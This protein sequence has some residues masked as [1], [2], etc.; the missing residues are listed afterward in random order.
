MK[1][2]NAL[3]LRQSL[4]K[5]VASLPRTGEP[6]L[7]EKGRKPVAVLISLGDFEERFAEKAVTEARER[8]LEEIDRLARRST[9]PTP[10]VEV[11][12]ELRGRG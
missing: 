6:I 4:G 9:D 12:R 8:I 10:A 1:R 5:V 11:L 3:A 2:V 7:L